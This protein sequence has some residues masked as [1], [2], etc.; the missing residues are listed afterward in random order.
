M[1]NTQDFDLAKLFQDILA[2]LRRERENLNRADE[3]N[4]NHG[5]H[6]VSIFDVAVKAAEERRDADLADKIEYAANSLSALRENGSAQ[7][8]HRGLRILAEQFRQRDIGFDIL[9]PYVRAASREKTQT[10][11]GQDDPRSA[12][13]L[14]ALLSALSAWDKDD[15]IQDSGSP[16]KTGDLDIGYLMGMGIAFMQAKQKGGDRL[17]VLAET[18]VSATPLSRVPHRHRS[19][20]LVMRTLLAA[21]SQA[22]EKDT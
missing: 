13:V 20:M 10:G 5:D 2:A 19:G 21:V 22:G 6:M 17:D 9:M 3:V 15:Q 12:E 4:Q 8:Y 18:A 16:V 7:E 14:K 11:D 1:S